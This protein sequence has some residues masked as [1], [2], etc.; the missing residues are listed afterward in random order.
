M[1]N[2]SSFLVRIIAIIIGIPMNNNSKQPLK[3][4]VCKILFCYEINTFPISK[5]VQFQK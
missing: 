1:L 5:T 2:L 3:S 4:V